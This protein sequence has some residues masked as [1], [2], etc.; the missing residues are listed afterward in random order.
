MATSAALALLLA[1]PISL[2]LAAAQAAPAQQPGAGGQAAPGAGGQA[3]P[4]AGG[5]AAPA[6][7]YKDRGE[8]DL[9][10][11]AVQQSKDPKTQLQTLQTWQD[12]YPKTDFETE[13][14]Q[15]FINA[16][17]QLA[18]NDP[19]AAKTLID[20]C[21]ALLKVDPKNFQGNYFLALW[22]PRVGGTS[23]QPDLLSQV[24]TASHGVLDNLP[25]KPANMS[26]ADWDKA[27]GAIQAVA[28]NALAWEAVQK[29]DNAAAENEYKASLQADPSQ[30]NVSAGYGRML[31]DDKDDKKIPQA[32]FEYA[33]ASQYDGTGALPADQRQK[34][35]DYVKT[36]YTNFHGN[37]EG[38][39]QLMAQ[40][41]TSPLPPDG[42]TIQSA[43][44]LAKG[45]ADALNQRIQSDPAF[46]I[47]YAIKQNLQDK[48]DAF[49]TSDVKDVEVPGGAEGVK[50]F[51]G[52][53][54][55][56]DPADRP[57]KVVLGVEDPT[58]PDA[59]LEFS[60][61]LP[62]DALNVIKVGQKIEFAGIA[63]A[64]TKDPYM[65]TFKDPTIPGVK[66]TTPARTGRKRR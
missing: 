33:R 37:T 34:L 15:L 26:D 30:A 54:I 32:L 29:K 1:G 42:F 27:K 62:P 21:N 8:Y 18:P 63:D 4:G 56:L 24:D 55:S 60:Q 28:H 43:N 17:R 48:G 19:A 40:A 64:F 45:Q 10:N 7:N 52:T 49:F 3:A 36:Q 46:K 44:D 31:I 5:Q 22:G 16:L 25:P 50:N 66:T 12:K 58:K 47:W 9:Y 53:V 39:D 51:S 57:T 6:K 11:Q 61:P 35:A 13:R 38:L 14:L 23:P 59:T 65:L 2:P 20:K 41:K